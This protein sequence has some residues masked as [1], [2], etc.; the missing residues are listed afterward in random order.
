MWL[1][2]QHDKPADFVFATGELHTVQDVVELA[3]K[4][5]GLDWRDHVKQDPRFMRANEPAR[6][7]GNTTKARQLLNW[8]PT[9]PFSQLITEMTQSAL[10]Q[11]K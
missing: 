3:F 4:A 2:L 7:L 6:L 9:T 5:V 10:H 1:A 11:P 8:H